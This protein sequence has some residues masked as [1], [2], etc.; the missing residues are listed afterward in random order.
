MS[1]SKTSTIGG[2]EINHSYMIIWAILLGLTLIEVLIPE[3]SMTPN[4]P[5]EL[6]GITISRTAAILSLV[7]LAI[8]KTYCVAIIFLCASS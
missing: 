2:F 5:K 8:T 3:M 4:G 6:M 1:E 7:G